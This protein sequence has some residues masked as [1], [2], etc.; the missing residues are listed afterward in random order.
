MMRVSAEECLAGKLGMPVKV[1]CYECGSR[2]PHNTNGD[3]DE[4][5][6][7]CDECGAHVV[8]VC[9]VEVTRRRIGPKRAG[10]GT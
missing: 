6:M 1:E 8:L 10:R 5:T 9:D 2:G 4:P 7:C 3:R